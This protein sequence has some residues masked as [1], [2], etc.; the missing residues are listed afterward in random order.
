MRALLIPTAREAIRGVLYVEQPAQVI[1]LPED[2]EAR[3]EKLRELVGGGIERIEMPLGHDGWINGNGKFEFHGENSDADL[4]WKR[5]VDDWRDPDDPENRML[6]MDGDYVAGP[7]VVTGPTTD[8]GGDT[9][10]TDEF[11]ALPLVGL[12]L[13]IRAA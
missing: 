6:R 7:V 9:P 13:R 2:E 10:V 8:E 1:D 11:L 12:A 3:F 4:L 5:A